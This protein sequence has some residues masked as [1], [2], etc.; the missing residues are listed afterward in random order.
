MELLAYSNFQSASAIL[1]TY[2]S[3]P[4]TWGMLAYAELTGRGHRRK[5]GLEV[6]KDVHDYIASV[7]DA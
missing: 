6:S 7:V 1:A 2:D 3:W 4:L 5:G